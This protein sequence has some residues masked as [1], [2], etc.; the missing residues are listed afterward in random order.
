VVTAQYTSEEY[1][2]FFSD[3][4][5]AG[6]T[7]VYHWINNK[8]GLGDFDGILYRG[9][10][11]NPNTK[12]LKNYLSQS[13]L[14]GS[15]TNF[16]TKMASKAIKSLV[17]VGPENQAAYENLNHMVD[18]SLKAESL[19]WLTAGKIDALKQRKTETYLIPMKSFVEKSGSFINFKGLEQKIS[20]ITTIVKGALT[21][22]EASNLLTG[23]EFEFSDIQTTHQLRKTNYFNNDRNRANE[24][25]PKT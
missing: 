1:K 23:G 6:V 21:L 17:V 24:F 5:K 18:L 15:W 4:Q 16:E 25:S 9:G 7:Q 13:G 14:Q 8:D 2:S 11:K 10:D 12:G 3:L 22:D 20:R 19:I